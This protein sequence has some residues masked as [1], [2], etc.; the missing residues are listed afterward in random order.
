MKIID[1]VIWFKEQKHNSE[2]GCQRALDFK[3][4]KIYWQIF[5]AVSRLTTQHV[6][7]EKQKGRP[8]ISN[9]C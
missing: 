5:I 2:V 7:Q 1:Y 3:T 9:N 6:G 8:R 4:K